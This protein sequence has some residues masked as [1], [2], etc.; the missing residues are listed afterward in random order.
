MASEADKIAGAI[1]FGPEHKHQDAAVLWALRQLIDRDRVGVILADEVG[2]GKTYEALAIAALLWRWKPRTSRILILAPSNL[3]LK[4]NEELMVCDLDRQGGRH[5]FPAYIV[6]EEWDGFRK[7]FLSGSGYYYFDRTAAVDNAWYGDKQFM[8]KRRRGSIQVPAGLYLVNKQLLYDTKRDRCKPLKYIMK[9]DWDLVIADEAHHY[10]RGGRC[11]S[12]FSTRYRGIGREAPNFGVEGTL[13]Y[14]KILLLTATP[15]ELQSAEMVNLFRLIRVPPDELVALKE[16]LSQYQKMLGLFYDLRELPAGNARRAAAVEAL[17]RGRFGGNGMPGLEELM[18]RSI[19]RNRK[20]NTEREYSLVVRNG[21]KWDKN[22]FDKFD[23]MRKCCSE[24]P[25]IPFTGTDALFYLEFRRLLSLLQETRRKKS[26]KDDRGGIFVAIDLQQGLSS[27]PQLLA[28]RE[29]LQENRLMGSSHPAAQRMRRML[30]NWTAA[31]RVHPKVAALREVVVGLVEAELKCTTEDPKSN[32][33]KI[34]VFNK[35]VAG[36]A[37]ELNKV[38]EKAL[39]PLLSKHLDLLASEKGLHSGKYA[40]AF[41]ER[42]VSESLPYLKK[43]LGE[44]QPWG[45]EGRMVSGQV[46]RL[47]KFKRQLRVQNDFV[48]VFGGYLKNRAGQP[49]FLINALRRGDAN[50]GEMVLRDAVDTDII[51]NFI[52][53]AMALLVWHNQ[54]DQSKSSRRKIET[55]YAQ[56]ISGL[57][58]K[59]RSPRLVARYD[60][61]TSEDRESNRQNFNS[62]WNPI[63]LLVSSVGEEGIDLQKQARYIIHYDIEWNPARMEQ[64]EGRVD[65]EGYRHEGKKIEVRFLLLKGTYEERIFH[66]VMRRDEWF[67]VLMGE[68]RRALGRI[69]DTPEDDH[70]IEVKLAQDVD[71]AVTDGGALT[72]AEREAVILDLRPK[73]NQR[74]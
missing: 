29:G 61:A 73:E 34:V 16:S 15:F 38:L 22:T 19:V 59:L 56:K 5:G 31:G 57:R 20:D 28:K 48:E 45:K 18:R 66:T 37:P 62:E 30:E 58:K 44:K 47:A 23:D 50:N 26:D 3:L 33:A 13:Q 42:V 24:L 9:T 64:R 11:D 71:A 74:Q 14:K 68:K 17:R 39:E 72:I 6:G 4:W 60:G 51:S 2:C 36:T 25:L 46:L 32:I 69:G 49:L 70:K 41:A 7:R 43:E 63:V 52:Y 40:R 67:Q 35:L 53:E 21:D 55:D 10:G 27:Y 12:I 8:G 65:R 54:S 1:S